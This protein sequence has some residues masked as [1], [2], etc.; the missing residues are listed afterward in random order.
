MS[1]ITELISQLKSGSKKALARCIS[2]VENEMPG[3]EE[4]LSTL[5][6]NNS[7]PII[8][9]TGAPGAGKSTLI[10]SLLKKLT[11]DQKKIGVIAVDPTSPFTF[12]SILG[13]RI[14]MED[15]FLNDNVFIR[16][17]AT[18]GSLGGLS[19][20]AIEI[21]DVMKSFGFDY[22]IIETVGVGQSEVEIMGLA[23][24]TVLVLVPEG[25]D[26]VQTIKSGIM[27]IAD[28]FVV[29]KCDRDGADKFVKNIHQLLHE[30]PASNWSPPVI[31]TVATSGV[32]AEELIE[33][34]TE[35][36]KSY[37]NERKTYLLAEKAYR[38]I[39]NEKMRGIDKS[40]LK[41]KIE[42]E[43][44]TNP[45]FSIYRFVKNIQK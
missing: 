27:E 39:Q 10:S 15:H 23:D 17:L 36:T 5:E 41:G 9:I 33:K 37:T 43:V 14:R 11:E 34:I 13:D 3:Y 32:G 16:S 45:S 42:E 21:S 12:G 19:A 40:E 25:G 26:E 29:N 1:S 2:I 31:K 28:I 8:G 22:I 6:P 4:L 30:K 35:H 38:L 44:R 18:R 24:T 7:I 20:K